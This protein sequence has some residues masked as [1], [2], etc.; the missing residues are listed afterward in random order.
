MRSLGRWVN[1]VTASAALAMASAGGVAA[2]GCV[3]TGAGVARRA[4]YHERRAEDLAHLQEANVE[5]LL[6]NES[7]DDVVVRVAAVS[8]VVDTAGPNYV[9][10]V[11]RATILGIVSEFGSFLLSWASVVVFRA[12]CDQLYV[13]GE[14]LSIGIPA[15]SN[16]DSVLSSRCLVCRPSY[17]RVCRVLSLTPSL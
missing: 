11:T 7:R 14:Y 5:K 12:Q 2:G 10:E 8:I 6:A 15:E 13:P 4:A 1:A 17:L 3:H 9:P 16:L